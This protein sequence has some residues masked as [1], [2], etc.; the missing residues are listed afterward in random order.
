VY[1]SA[2]NPDLIGEYLRAH[3]RY[4]LVIGAGEYLDHPEINNRA[5]VQPTA[6]LVDASLA[7]LGYE[8]LPGVSQR[9]EPFLIGKDA[10]RK[11]ID[12]ALKEMAQRTGGQDFG[13]IYYVGHGNI[14]STG[15][16]L[17]LGIYDEPVASDRGYLTSQMLGLLQTGSVYRTAITEIPHLFVVLDAYFSGT[18]AQSFH[19]VIETIEGV[20][21][22]V[23]V[24]GGGPIIAEQ[25]AVLTATAPG[26]AKRAYE[27]DGTG[28][29]AFGYYFARALRKDWVCSDSLSH[30]GIL[31][32][33]EMEA[34]LDKHLKLAYEKGALQAEMSPRVLAGNKDS[35]L[36]Y[37]ADKYAE[38]GFRDLIYSILVKPG[39]YET[40]Y[41]TMPGGAQIACSD[42]VSGCRVPFS[43]SYL[44]ANLTLAVAKQNVTGLG[45]EARTVKL[46]DLTGASTTVLGVALHVNKDG[47]H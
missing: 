24:S 11:A 38:P 40:A 41:L 47:V 34:Y 5:Y 36:A 16:D 35:L 27:L 20:Q 17:S 45:G 44:N 1:L 7:E 10:N 25:V 18:I 9:G 12:A 43:K 23:E 3:K 15:A 37:R 21:R 33:Q 39:Q 30:D 32:L 28:L 26:S 46:A 42:S 8:A 13:I 4:R 29:S 31:T 19:T 6:R 14:T 22:L 2:P